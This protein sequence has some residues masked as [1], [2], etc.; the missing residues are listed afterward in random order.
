MII[1]KKYIFETKATRLKRLA[2]NTIIIG[3]IICTLLSGLL[4]FI[5]ISASNQNE[6]TL[7]FLIK[8][9]PDLIAVFTGDS[10]R[11]EQA[12]KLTKKYPSA[13]LFISGVHKKNSFS[14]LLNKQIENPR[15]FL[16]NQNIN[17][18]IDYK[19]KNTL[20][21]VISTIRFIE[22]KEKYSNIIIVSSDYHIL[23]ISILEDIIKNDQNINF[24]Y[25]PTKTDYSKWNNIKKI[26]KE[27]IKILKTFSLYLV[28]DD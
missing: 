28:W 3:L 23:R 8:E 16:E 10:K 13:K 18:V 7:A 4:V 6:R 22:G 11:I 12:L 24:Y 2:I 21:N 25:Y 15:E 19:S 20:E 26:L 1:S 14:T 5:P 9:S 17:A 27:S